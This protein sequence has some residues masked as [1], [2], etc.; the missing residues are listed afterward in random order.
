M[1]LIPKPV[2]RAFEGLLQPV[3][4]AMIAA[5]IRPNAITTAGTLVL[6]GSA[7]AFGA[8]RVRTGAALLLLS[9]VLDMLDG[10]VARGSGGVTDFGAFYDSTLDRIG[11]AALFAG[12]TVFFVRGGVVGPWLVPAVVTSL[13]ALAAGLIVSYARAR[14][15]GL[16]LE[17]KVGMAQRAERVLGLGAPTMIFGAGPNGLLLFAVVTVLALISVV[18]IVQRIVHVWKTTRVVPRQTQAV[19]R[20]RIAGVMTERTR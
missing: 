2:Q 19:D 10:R 20:S 4:D 9:G 5:G 6:V 11:E 16:G 13:V 3:V 8:G 12:I 7:A 15:E 14:A 17:C 18:T 1:A